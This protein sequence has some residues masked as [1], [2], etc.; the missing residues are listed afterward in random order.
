M[1]YS[2]GSTR[3]TTKELAMFDTLTPRPAD[4]LLGLMAAYRAD[5]RADK[6]DLGVG[7]FRDNAGN[8][9]ILAAVRDAE[10][11]LAE[12]ATTKV[13]E[14]PRGNMVFGDG[15]A[16][17]LYGEA[18][19]K[20]RCVTFATPGGCGALSLSA[21]FLKRANP[22]AT[23]WM[24]NPT[25][26]NHGP[27]MAAAGL[28]TTPYDYAT[29]Y[30]A[31][32]DLD[33]MLASL[34]A[35]APGDVVL[36]QGPCHNPTGIDLS[37]AQWAALG[38]LCAEKNLLPL[39]DIAYHG[40]S[41]SLEEDLKGVQA[42]L[43]RVEE[44]LIAYSCSKNFGLYRERSGC[45][46]LQSGSAKTTEVATTH[47]ADIA[48]A[49]YSMPPA[50]GPA[51]VATILGDP[52]LKQAWVE[53]VDAMRARILMLRRTLAEALTP[54]SNS[55]D[56]MLLTRQHGMFSLLPFVE[57]GTDALKEQGIYIPPSGR[58]NI[59]GLTEKDVARAAEAMGAYL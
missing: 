26:P 3:A 2:A 51:I 9:P 34:K 1:F 53:E 38:D 13:Y 10:R 56:P 17:L 23:V 5:P 22:G 48:R 31:A 8:T 49:S 29:P 54:R 12:T 57:G 41:A 47:L 24:S 37:L 19:P 32:P 14:G 7:V 25:W 18:V 45:L 21:V 44:A 46:V 30:D 4:M 40:F 27:I 52:A 33:K 16:R 59:A 39:I 42:L 11:Q 50:H 15:I 36:L 43:A 35:A 55:Y 6:I 58:I 20:D 28:Q